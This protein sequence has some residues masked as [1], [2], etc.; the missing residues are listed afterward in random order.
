[1][2]W[3][4]AVLPKGIFGHGLLV[5]LSQDMSFSSECACVCVLL[6]N[7]LKILGVLFPFFESEKF[8]CQYGILANLKKG[9]DRNL[10]V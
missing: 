2:S 5:F 10:L 8:H 3:N 9:K 1:M 7:I 4:E 6:R